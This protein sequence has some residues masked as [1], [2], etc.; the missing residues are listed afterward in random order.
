MRGSRILQFGNRDDYEI[1]KVPD[2]QIARTTLLRARTGLRAGIVTALGSNRQLFVISGPGVHL[3]L[4]VSTLFARR[5]RF[6][7]DRVLAPDV[8][9]YAPADGIHFVQRFRQ[10]RDAARS[11]AHHLQ[12]VAG[13]AHVLFAFQ[14]PDGI[15]GWPILGLE[16]PYSLLKRMPALVIVSIG[17]HKNHFLFEFGA[18]PEVRRRRHH[19]VIERG[20]SARL[21]LFQSFLQLLDIAG[22]LLVEVELVVKV[23]DAH[24]I[25]GIGSAHQIHGGGVHFLAFFPHRSRVV[26]HNAHSDGNVFVAK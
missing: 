26:D 3:H 8:V 11:L 9:G 21:D 22:E 24:F 16:T 2:Y 17:H 7:S 18:F 23:N 6:V 19:R 20:S 4:A 13:V 10:D 12:G 25:I 1:T 5:R 15:Y 14:N